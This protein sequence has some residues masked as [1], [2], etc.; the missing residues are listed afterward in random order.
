MQ[1]FIYMSNFSKGMKRCGEI[2]LSMAKEVYAEKRKMKAINEGGKVEPVELM[3]PMMTEGGELKMENDLSEAQFDVNV[4]VGPSS[5]SKRSA[6]VRA[7]TGMMQMVQDPET[8]QVLTSMAM[9]NME[10]EGISDI[11]DYFRQKMIR[12]G[13]VKPSDKE[14]EAMQAESANKQP[15]PNA[16]FLAAA[17]EEA[18]AK[19]AQARATVIKTLADSDLSKAKTME[20]LANVDMQEQQQAFNML[21]DMGGIAQDMQ[22]PATT[23]PV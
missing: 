13:A 7:I 20:T 2:W 5:S 15:D 10:G 17:A 6:T 4:E 22:P 21:K 11:R 19:A 8:M 16:Q 9:M 14:M 12:M 3:K 23:Q 18:Q 1:T